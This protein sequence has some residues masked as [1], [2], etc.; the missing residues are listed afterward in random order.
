MGVGMKHLHNPPDKRFAIFNKQS[1]WYKS[2]WALP[3][4]KQDSWI[5]WLSYIK[6]LGQTAVVIS[7]KSR[8]CA[9]TGPKLAIS[10]VTKMIENLRDQHFLSLLK[11]LDMFVFIRYHSPRWSSRSLGL[12]RHFAQIANLGS[13]SIYTYIRRF[14]VG[15]MSIRRRSDGLC[16]LGNVHRWEETI[17]Q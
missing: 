3:W 16:Y 9:L 17:S 11:I 5:A 2:P 6:L 13:T 7:S 14:R 4:W 12:L 15:S 10:I 8:S 1:K